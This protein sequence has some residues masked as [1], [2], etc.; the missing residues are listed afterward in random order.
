MCRNAAVDM[1][2]VRVVTTGS[3]GFVAG[4]SRSPPAPGL[5][6]VA[7]R[8]PCGHTA[9]GSMEQAAAAPDVHGAVVHASA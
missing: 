9:A 5:L 4:Y 8:E 7:P 2:L 3:E 1:A 6:Q